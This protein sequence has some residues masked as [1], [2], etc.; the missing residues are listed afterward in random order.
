MLQLRGWILG[1]GAILSFS[2]WGESVERFNE[3]SK[4]YSSIHSLT[5]CGQYCDLQ[6]FKITK[7]DYKVY[8]S[9]GISFGSAMYASFK[10]ATNA[11][12]KKYGIVQFVK[13][14]HFASEKQNGKMEKWFPRSRYHFGKVIKYKHSRWAVDSYDL[15]PMYASTEENRYW[16]YKWNRIPGSHEEES[17]ELFRNLSPTTPEIYVSNFPGTAFQ[18]GQ[19]EAINISLKFKTCLYLR[20]DIPLRLTTH[21]MDTTKAISCFDW[22]SSFIYNYE[23][24]IY[25][26]QE[27]IDPVC[28]E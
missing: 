4:I 21:Y 16:S 8:L 1:T 20:D 23:R 27:K 12:L 24:K 18:Y 13:G 22:S 28:L 3:V 5:D 9:E 26:V 15:D 7:H 10:T 2:I 25:E 17:E 14:C 6:E 19:N 11:S